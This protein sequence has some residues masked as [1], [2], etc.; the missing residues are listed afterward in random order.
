MPLSLHIL[1]ADFYN[2]LNF[3]KFLK[4]FGVDK[5]TEIFRAKKKFKKKFFCNKKSFCLH[6]IIYENNQIKIQKFK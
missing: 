5:N 4:V 2:F 3:C 1:F 6:T